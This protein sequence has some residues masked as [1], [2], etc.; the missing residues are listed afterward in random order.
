MNTLQERVSEAMRLDGPIHKLATMLD[1]SPSTLIKTAAG[2]YEPK[3]TAR[4]R[5]IKGLSKLEAK[6]VNQ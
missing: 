5:L 3:N 2:G 6:R 1:V 4:E